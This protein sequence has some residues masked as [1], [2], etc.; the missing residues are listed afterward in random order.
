MPIL[1]VRVVKSGLIEDADGARAHIQISFPS[2]LAARSAHSLASWVA[3][4]LACCSLFSLAAT[5][6]C[7]C[8]LSITHVIVL[9]R[10]CANCWGRL[11]PS[12]LRE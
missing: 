1:P 5:E 2:K 11:H 8:L 7:D 12:G 10:L 9:R 6:F 3:G 4:L